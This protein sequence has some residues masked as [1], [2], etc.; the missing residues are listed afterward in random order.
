MTTDDTPPFEPPRDLIERAQTAHGDADAQL[1]AFFEELR[2]VD[3]I[4]GAYGRRSGLSLIVYLIFDYICENDGTS[5]REICAYTLLP[6]QSVNNVVDSLAA[7]GLLCLEDSER[8]RRVKRIRLTDE[9]L[10]YRERII[11]PLRGAE[12]R[13]MAELEPA[14]R[15]AMIAYVD[16][17]MNALERQ[18][19][20]LER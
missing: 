2:R 18:I 10:R 1:L 7:Q 4:Y 19:G 20:A 11:D 15:R 17:F 9:G 12:L 8:D 14:E 6:R 5:Q 16:K 3:L 13:A